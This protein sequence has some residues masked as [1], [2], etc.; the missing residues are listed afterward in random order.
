M[1]GTA[2][3]AKKAV[4]T[5]YAKHGKDFFKIQG[6]K[7]GKNGHTGGFAHGEEGRARARIVGAIGGRISRRTSKKKEVTNG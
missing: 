1:S 4:K 3:G 5:I 6:Y 7:G 2:A